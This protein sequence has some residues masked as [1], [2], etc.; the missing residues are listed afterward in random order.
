MR[1]FT[2]ISDVV[3]GII[4]SIKVNNSCKIFNLGNN[5]PVKLL[6]F[7]ET[8]EKVSGKT[9]EKEFLEFQKGDVH[10]TFADL[11]RTK[12]ELNWSPK[13]SLEEGLDEFYSWYKNYYSY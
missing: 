5:S 13:T 3:E 6:T 1:D 12:A 8:L 10:S 4:Q 2:H 9:F 7:I 11:D